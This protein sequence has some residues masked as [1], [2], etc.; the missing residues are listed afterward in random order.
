MSLKTTFTYV[1]IPG[2]LYM[3]NM[4]YRIWELVGANLCTLSNPLPC[5]VYT[6]KN[7]ERLFLS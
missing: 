4:N 1:I 6:Y 5:Y 2:V 7:K 3:I